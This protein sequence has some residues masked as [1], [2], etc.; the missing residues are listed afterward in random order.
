MHPRPGRKPGTDNGVPESGTWKR[1]ENKGMKTYVIGNLKGGVGKTT[2][3]VNLMY[4]MAMQGKRV[5]GIDADPQANLTPFFARAASRGRTVR[6]VLQK[7]KAIRGAIYRSR[8]P[9]IDIVKG[10]TDLRETDAASLGELWF[11]L[12]AV[13]TRYDVC[14]IDTR[15]AFERITLNALYA[16]DT[17]LVPVCLDKFCR[18]NLLVVEERLEDIQQDIGP[19][20]LSWHVF[21]NKVENKRAQRNTYMDMVERHSWPFLETCISRGAVVSNALEQYKP[22][23]RHRSKC[24][25]AQDYMELA[26]EL[27]EG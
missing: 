15:P 3:A 20:A 1:K 8:Y 21:A 16:A 10:S 26:K 11:A 14:F 6:D 9:H 27:L 22:V 18:D 12:K 19:R 24:Q 4:S 13:E 23:A 17:L 25:V 2:S 5:L 7:P